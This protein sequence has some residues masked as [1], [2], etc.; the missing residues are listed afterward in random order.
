MKVW[1]RCISALLAFIMLGSS[2]NIALAA[3]TLDTE[4]NVW[5][6][7]AADIVAEHYGLASNTR[8]AAVI[9][10]GAIRSGAAYQAAAP[11]SNGT[12]EKQDL[13][14]VDYINKVFYV[15]EYEADGCTWLPAE[16]ELVAE[17]EVQESFALTEEACYYNDVEYYA[18]EAFTYDGNSYTIKV[19][20]ELSVDIDLE[21][22][23]RI[24]EIPAHLGQAVKNIDKTL[25]GMWYN[26]QSFGS[27][28]P[29]LYSMLSMSYEVEQTTTTT[30]EVDGEMVE[31]TVTELVQE[32]FFK[33]EEH[34][35]EIAAITALYNE[36][37][38][39]P[40]D[41]KLDMF[42]VCDDSLNSTDSGLTY[43][44]K[45]GEKV[46]D[47][48]AALYE[49]LE[50]LSKSSR[51]TSLY[52][53]L[54]TLDP[55]LY[56]SLKT[57]YRLL[58]GFVGSA[59]K[60]GTLA[61]LKN[62][63]NWSIIE[64]EVQASIFKEN[65][66]AEEFARLEASCYSLRNVTYR[67][68]TAVD[69]TLVAGRVETSCKITTYDITVTAYA[70]V[71]DEGVGND[72]LID[73][74]PY[75][76]TVT[77]LAGSAPEEVEE[78]VRGLGLE[79]YALKKWNEENADYQI[80][81]GYYTRSKTVLKENLQS[82]IPD[83]VIIYE[84][85]YYTV[86]TDYD[87]KL[88]VPFRY[89]LVFPENTED[90]GWYDYTVIYE[91]GNKIAYNQ[92]MVFKVTSNIEVTR[93]TGAAKT[94]YRLLDFLAKDEQYN[95]SSEAQRILNNPALES[96]MLKIRVPDATTVGNIEDVEGGFYINAPEYPSG[97]SGMVWKA[98]E[99]VLVDGAATVQKVPVSGDRADWVT[100]GFTHVNVNY[101]MGVTRVRDGFASRKLSEE[102]INEYANLPHVLVQEVSAQDE[103]LGGTSGVTARTV[104]NQMSS[105]EHLMSLLP[106]FFELMETDDGKNAIL[107][108][109]AR[110]NE[111]AKGVNG[112]KLGCGGWSSTSEEPAIYK[113]L[114][115]CQDSNFSVAAYYQMGYEDEMS[116]QAML[117][118][119]CLEAL[120]GDPGF[121]TLLDTFGMLDKKQDI[122]ALVPDLRELSDNLDSPHKSL[123]INDPQFSVLIEDILAAKGK[124]R[125]YQDASSICAYTTVRKNGEN[126]GSIQVILQ[127]DNFERTYSLG[128]LLD[129]VEGS[130]RYHTLTAEEE[131]ALDREINAM[132]LACGITSGTEKFYD[133]SLDDV[134]RAGDKLKGSKN[135]NLT[136]TA[137]NYVVT[138]DGVPD[139]EYRA[140]FRYGSDYVIPLPAKSKRPSD[141]TYY[142]YTFLDE[143]GEVFDT[144]AVENGTTGSFAF[145]E[146]QLLTLFSNGGYVIY[147]E[148][149]KVKGKPSLALN[150]KLSNEMI[151]G[152]EVDKRNMML[153][154]DVHPDGINMDE[155]LEQV[156][157]VVEN[158]TLRTIEIYDASGMRLGSYSLISTGSIVRYTIEDIYGK[159]IELEYTVIMMGDVNGDGLCNSEDV[160]LT[161]DVYF[162]EKDK[163]GN[164][165]DEFPLSA[166]GAL[167]AN[168]NNNKQIDTNDAWKIRSKALYWDGDTKQSQIIY[169]SVLK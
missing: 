87:G 39:T 6:A 35:A 117:M 126:S 122:K 109:Q 60:E 58:N 57:M 140:T 160:S 3:G 9:S 130:E 155:Y 67:V 81:T 76:D 68:P 22:Q 149:Q 72:A 143:N 88:K 79:D 127:V 92:G 124:T 86:K 107:R 21:E 125:A 40:E 74:T 111:T 65:Y 150:P 151:R 8:L 106:S 44:M 110:E 131:A 158:A 19:T 120:T 69:E 66:D 46:R 152:A 64:P 55:A 156:V 93:T 90:D 23:Q 43:A 73:L 48:S 166:V 33:E 167:A 128:Y 136:Y 147:R 142:Q 78:A 18:S 25:S 119:D 97:M 13:T 17:G 10:N 115:M 77:L 4:T 168:M 16:A 121:H 104:Y 161:T 42:V 52:A 163:K 34:A 162:L 36:Y 82:D 89:Q 2:T 83:Y 37:M 47:T 84:P 165:I 164:Y 38:Q 59:A 30:E 5:S 14:A 133:T 1:K 123:K 91:D 56:S 129:T 103:A 148:E 154:L 20:Y 153:F 31:T 15:K 29:S 54:K 101:K 114:K 141:K 26:L 169:R 11:Y 116:E 71:T 99:A 108:M 28:I 102:E 50:V 45:N 27:M 105:Y 32:P 80:G 112:E 132:K 157:P 159:R 118:A 12:A 138:I 137:K 100:A 113:Y 95:M 63:D 7:S 135:V 139:K 24:L 98:Q 85:N 96:P 94:E 146:N 51:L 145:T 62:P 75:T 144:R 61:T 41:P 70:K 53:R 134:P 49:K